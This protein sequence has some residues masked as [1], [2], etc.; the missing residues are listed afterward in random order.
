MLEKHYDG[1]AGPAWFLQLGMFSEV[2]FGSRSAGW[3]FLLWRNSTTRLAAQLRDLGTDW[4]RCG[5][6]RFT[7]SSSPFCVLVV[8]ALFYALLPIS[9]V[10]VARCVCVRKGILPHDRCDCRDVG[11]GLRYH[12]ARTGGHLWSGV[13]LLTCGRERLLRRRHDRSRRRITAWIRNGRWLRWCLSLWTECGVPLLKDARRIPNRC[14]LLVA[15]DRLKGVPLLR[16]R[17]DLMHA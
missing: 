2:P 3:L 10:A 9:F 6:Q 13:H 11:N 17:R 7:N 14:M 4:S 15:D 1:F 5:A 16:C 12:G 8:M